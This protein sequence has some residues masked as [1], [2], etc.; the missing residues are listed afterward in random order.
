M[1]I[2]FLSTFYPF[3]GGIAQFNANLRLALQA[4]G[5]EVVPFTFTRQYIS[6]LFPGK[7]QYV[8]EK[9]KAIKVDSI[10]VLDPVN[11]FTYR[12]A[13]RRILK[14]KPDVLFIRYWMSYFAPSLGRVAR[15]VR[16][17]GVKVVCLVDNAFSHEPK[18]F[19]KTLSGWMIRSCDEIIVMSEKVKSD[20]LSIEK[21]ASVSVARHPLYTNFGT[22]VP[23]ADAVKKLGLNPSKKILLFF[24]LIREYK[25]LDIVLD[26]M[27]LLGPSYQLVVAGEC[28]GSFDSYAEQIE[29]INAADS[30]RVKV[31]NRYI[32]D[33]EVPL[34]FSAADLCV[35][36]Y[37]SATQSG[38]TAVAYIFD[39]PVVVTPV[40]SLTAEVGDT[41]VGVVADAV[42]PQAVAAAVEK[43]FSLPKVQFVNAIH[44][45]KE[46]RTWSK[47]ARLLVKC[48]E[49]FKTKD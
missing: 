45:E 27:N 15:L 18:P 19:E 31:F 49:L 11:P 36:P 41:G 14:E 8:T 48:G 32:G 12:R 30:D 17:H 26:A 37:R 4:E 47:L 6:W 5:H 2:C 24:G 33:E 43:Y 46:Q 42:T 23:K 1:K 39:L 25:G 28:Y 10:P 3:R 20:V 38:I 35:L 29:Q 44:T 22:P 34:F 16:R 21:D 40:G 13:A 7:T 9:D